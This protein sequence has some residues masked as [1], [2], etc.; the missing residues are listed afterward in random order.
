MKIVIVVIVIVIVYSNSN[1]NS[2]SNS[3]S[4]NTTNNKKI[5]KNNNILAYIYQQIINTNITPKT[6]ICMHQTDEE[7]HCQSWQKVYF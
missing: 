3:R 6:I 7:N 2:D 5:N 4:D 1:Y